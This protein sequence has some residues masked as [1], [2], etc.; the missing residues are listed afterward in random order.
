MARYQVTK[1]E[2]EPFLEGMAIGGTGGGG[3]PSWGREI[4]NNDF[5]KGRKYDLVDPEDVADDALIVSGGIMGSVKALD[6]MSFT[7][8]LEGWEQKFELLEVLRLTERLLGRKV[9]YMVPFEIGALNTPVIMSVCARA[10]IPCINGD[11]MGRAAPET[12]MSSFIGHGISLTP[13]PLVDRAGNAVIVMEGVEPTFPDQLGRWVVTQGGGLGANN[14][15]PMSGAQLKKSVVSKSI[16]Q[17]LDLGKKVVAARESGKDPIQVTVDALGGYYLFNGK[18]VVLNEEDRGG[19][20]NTYAKIAGTGRWEGSVCELAIKNE[21]MLCIIDG[22]VRTVFPDLLCPVDPTTGRGI[23]SVELE[24]GKELAIV[25]A[26]VDE[27]VR[28]ARRDP[29]GAKSLSPSR[30]GY[31]DVEYVPI[32]DLVKL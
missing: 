6:Y 17:F 21:L 29:I 32:E 20:L 31:P 11:G 14:H 12:Q 27:R 19:F 22:Q 1:D 2:I 3:T 10:G 26:P 5:A 23:M 25:G 9:D 15:Y 4:M 30:F 8:I 24:P 16:T 13:M 18:I 28:E 7:E